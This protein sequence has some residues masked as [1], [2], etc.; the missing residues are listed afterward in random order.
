MYDAIIKEL[1]KLKLSDKYEPMIDSI[2][3]HGH[4]MYVIS[5]SMSVEVDLSSFTDTSFERPIYMPLSGD[6]ES[7][8]NVTDEKELSRLYQAK[9]FLSKHCDTLIFFNRERVVDYVNKSYGSH[10]K[11]NKMVAEVK[12]DDRIAISFNPTKKSTS[13]LQGGIDESIIIKPRPRIRA[14]KS[15]INVKLLPLTL[16]LDNLLLSETIKLEIDRDCQ[17]LRISCFH[18]GFR[19]KFSVLSNSMTNF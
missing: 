11:A 17:F 12:I 19:V 18:D 6:F 1:S 3:L 2:Y 9:K 5:Q 16:A 7:S 10:A 8:D 15:C 13:V 14:I 4:S